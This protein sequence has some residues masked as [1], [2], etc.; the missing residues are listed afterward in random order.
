MRLHDWPGSGCRLFYGCCCLGVCEKHSWSLSGGCKPGRVFFWKLQLMIPSIKPSGDNEVIWI[1]RRTSI[2]MAAASFVIFAI[3]GMDG[4]VFPLLVSVLFWATL[5]GTLFSQAKT[6]AR[7]NFI[8]AIW[9]GSSIAVLH[10]F[11]LYDWA[12]A[13]SFFIGPL[14]YQAVRE[15]MEFVRPTEAG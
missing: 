13:W 6:V 9:S 5:N 4:M 15:V 2:W 10:M 8:S 7:L 1:H 12:S 11:V 3:A 14:L